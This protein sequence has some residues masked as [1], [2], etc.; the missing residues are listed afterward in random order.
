MSLVLLL[1]QI[2]NNEVISF[3]KTIAIITENYHYHPTEF[4]N[5]LAENK[6]TNAAGTNEGS[7][8]I[9]SF[10]QINQLNQ[11]QT[12]SLFGDFYKK[13]VLDNPTGNDHQNIRN[14]MEFGWEGISYPVQALT[15]K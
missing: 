14:F 4:S 8:K 12:L 13:D 1:E 5:G 3:D 7:C 9:F 6:L 10:A 15:A 2:K 11:Q